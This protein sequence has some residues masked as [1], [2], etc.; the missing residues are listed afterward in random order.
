M[1]NK[2]TAAA[3]KDFDPESLCLSLEQT[4]NT[5]LA[6]SDAMF[7]SPNSSSLYAPGI[8]HC[9]DYL[10]A[11]AQQIQDFVDFCLSQQVARSNPVS[12]NRQQT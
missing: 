11:L 5:L 9:S 1:D 3:F 4:A 10:S 6:I 2:P 7:Y 8:V 12:D